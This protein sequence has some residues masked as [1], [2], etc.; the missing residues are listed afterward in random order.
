MFPTGKGTVV[1]HSNLVKPSMIPGAGAQ[2]LLYTGM[3]G[4]RHFYACWCIDRG[5]PGK[6]IQEAWGIQVSSSPW[7]PTATYSRA[8]TM[9]PRSTRRSAMSWTRH[10]R[11]MLA[12]R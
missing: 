1:E 7:T 5:M 11:D 8:V 10:R 12:K 9:Q 4:F 2:E 3:H 6:V